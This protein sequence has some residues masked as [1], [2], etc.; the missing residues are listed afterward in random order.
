MGSVLTIVVGVVVIVVLVIGVYAVYLAVAMRARRPAEPGFQ[1]I[2]VEDD[3]SAREVTEAER[4]RLGTQYA[5][6]DSR[7]PYIK[8]RYEARDD[9]GRQRGFLKRRQLPARVPISTETGHGDRSS[10]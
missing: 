6:T 8:L 9:L 5:A 7:R 2:Y 4:R 10:G 1:Y 3:G